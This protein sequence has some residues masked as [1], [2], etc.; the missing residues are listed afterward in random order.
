MSLAETTMDDTIPIYTCKRCGHIWAKR[1]WRKIKRPPGTC[2]HCK[3]ALWNVA[4][5][6]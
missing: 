6:E 3:S 5:D 2:P 4:K 1:N